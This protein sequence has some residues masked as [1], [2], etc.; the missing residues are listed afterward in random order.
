PSLSYSLSL[1]DALPILWHR[2]GD[3]AGAAGALSLAELP[4]GAGQR[5]DPPAVAAGQ[6][7]ADLAP[8][9]AA[10]RI[11]A[12]PGLRP[13]AALSRRRRRDRKSTRLNSSHVKI[14]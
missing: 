5:R 3:P 14:S 13:A 7:A 10:T 1:H 9:A 2:R 4:S 6:G 12:G 8:G 11:A